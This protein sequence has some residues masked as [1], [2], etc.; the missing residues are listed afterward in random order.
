MG[1]NRPVG[2]AISVAS[3]L[4][5][6]MSTRKRRPILMSAIRMVAV[7]VSCGFMTKAPSHTAACV[8]NVRQQFALAL[9]SG[10]QNF[11]LL[12]RQMLFDCGPHEVAQLVRFDRIKF[13]TDLTESFG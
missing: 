3:E 7:A 13:D 8:D 2:L 12:S 6:P 11:V 5:S 10:L 9:L 1:C 4:I